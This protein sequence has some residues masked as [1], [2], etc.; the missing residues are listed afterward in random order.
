MDS[1]PEEIEE[2]EAAESQSPAKTK[3]QKQNAMRR[4]KEKQ[5]TMFVMPKGHQPA[6]VPVVIQDNE[7][8]EPPTPPLSPT[9]SHPP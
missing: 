1:I 6:R 8:C 9:R 4:I 2:Q 3:S 5:T 7:T